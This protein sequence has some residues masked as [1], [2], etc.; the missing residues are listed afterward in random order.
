VALCGVSAG[1]GC[2]NPNSYY[3]IVQITG[4]STQLAP[5]AGGWDIHWDQ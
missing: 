1:A 4:T 2:A 5:D 3:D